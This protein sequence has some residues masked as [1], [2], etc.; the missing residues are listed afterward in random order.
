MKNDKLKYRGEI[1]ELGEIKHKSKSKFIQVVLKSK[2]SDN[3]TN[4]VKFEAM[5]DKIDLFS[6]LK[7]KDKV[8]I[9]FNIN[10]K[11]WV[12]DNGDKLF[13]IDLHVVSV[14]VL[15]VYTPNLFDES[16]IE[17]ESPDN[18]DNF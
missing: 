6:G 13:Y 9:D 10:G 1:Y 14:K 8:E 12:K 18:F 2:R 16:V 3:N 11:E 4:L 7:I 5:N 17:L 15:K